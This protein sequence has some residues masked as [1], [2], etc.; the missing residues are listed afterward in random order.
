MEVGMIAE[1]VGLCSVAEHALLDFSIR[2]EDGGD[3]EVGMK[4]AGAH[5]VEVGEVFGSLSA[6]LATGGDGRPAVVVTTQQ[7]QVDMLVSREDGYQGHVVSDQPEPD[8][9]RQP[10][11]HGANG[12]AAIHKD[13]L[14]VLDQLLGL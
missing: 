4:G 10:G 9:G 2:L 8:V 7:D 14:P 13:G 11:R 5:E 1:G 3:A 12:R 6:G